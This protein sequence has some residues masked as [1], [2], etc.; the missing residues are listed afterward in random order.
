MGTKVTNET[1]MMFRRRHLICSDQCGTPAFVAEEKRIKKLY[2]E[3]GD[4]VGSDD[5][6]GMRMSTDI[7]SDTNFNGSSP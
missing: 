6:L 7:G 2:H 5:E 4:D 3:R 1:Y